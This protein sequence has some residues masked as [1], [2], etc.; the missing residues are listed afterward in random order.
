MA[1]NSELERLLAD[2]KSKGRKNE[3]VS[4][5]QLFLIL[6][7]LA[8]ETNPTLA[9]VDAKLR[10]STGIDEKQRQDEAAAAQQPQKKKRAAQVRRCCGPT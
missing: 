3:G 6:G 10:A 7:G 2:A 4:T 1:R 5:A 8:A 9:E